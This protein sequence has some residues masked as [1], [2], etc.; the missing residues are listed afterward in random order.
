MEPFWKLIF[1]EKLAV[2]LVAAETLPPVRTLKFPNPLRVVVPGKIM[3]P[4]AQIL[5]PDAFR[6]KLLRATKLIAVFRQ[7]IAELPALA[8]N[9]RLFR[10]G[11]EKPLSR[12][13]LPK[14]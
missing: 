13:I 11:A 12:Q 6:V 2:K 7:I 5:K 3:L 10:L 1:P 9:V 14:L 4:L 8:C